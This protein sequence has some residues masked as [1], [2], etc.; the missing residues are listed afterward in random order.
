MDGK[1][2]TINVNPED[3]STGER[4]VECRCNTSKH[5]CCGIQNR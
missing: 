2:F 1:G 3:D 4:G 5:Y